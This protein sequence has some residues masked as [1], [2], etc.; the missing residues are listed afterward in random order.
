MKIQYINNNIL[1]PINLEKMLCSC[2]M[3]EKGNSWNV[4]FNKNI[5][6]R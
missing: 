5:P 3:P 6:K 1:I 2:L 4:Q